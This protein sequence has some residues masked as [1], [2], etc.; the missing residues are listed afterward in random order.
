MMPD[1]AAQF[2]PSYSP[3]LWQALAGLEGHGVPRRLAG[4][5]LD[6]WARLA[7]AAAPEP[8]IE[9][10][11]GAVRFTWSFEALYLHLDVLE[12]GFSWF[13]EDDRAQVAGGTRAAFEPTIPDA[14]FEN[15]SK[16]RAGA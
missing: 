6:T 12:E 11:D 5:A 9:L 14:F 3:E 10:P 15:L 16:I 13:F 2:A 4:R 7:R 1:A 8:E